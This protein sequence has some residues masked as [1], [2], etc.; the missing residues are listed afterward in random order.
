MTH[1]RSGNSEIKKDSSLTST[2]EKTV[3]FKDQI[4]LTSTDGY[5]KEAPWFS[6]AN[7]TRPLAGLLTRGVMEI[8]TGELMVS[9]WAIPSTDGG[10][11]LS[12]EIDWLGYHHSHHK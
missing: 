6:G 3:S 4:T 7:P 5:G 8:S 12:K 1:N 2:S 11:T 10:T 9:S